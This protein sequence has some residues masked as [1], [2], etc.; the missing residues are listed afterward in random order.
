[1][2]IGFSL[3]KLCLS[4]SITAIAAGIFYFHALA[5][6]CTNPIVY[7]APPLF[8]EQYLQHIEYL[9]PLPRTEFDRRFVEK[10]DLE[11]LI[12]DYTYEEI[13]VFKAVMT[14]QYD[15]ELMRL[16][17]HP[18]KMQRIKI[19]EAFAAVQIQFIHDE[20]S[21][22]PPKRN[23]LFNR[24]G[25]HL[26]DIRNALSEALIYT[27]VEGKANRIPYTLAWLPG[28]GRET[29]ELFS[30]AAKHHPDHNIRR[31]SIY[32]VTILE[33]GN[34]TG[35]LLLGR[36]KD[37]VYSVRKLALDL[38]IRRLIGNI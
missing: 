7:K 3:K 13:L 22:F 10:P 23:Q 4:V 35:P 25:E 5:G 19:A 2:V 24:L 36:S 28:Q 20:E 17:S 31:S 30:W 37:P 34:L 38:R 15:D 33:G 9:E 11:A 29:L 32:Y 26:P 18:D 14:G 8:V 6:F 27:A 16:F 21:G 12:E 1:M